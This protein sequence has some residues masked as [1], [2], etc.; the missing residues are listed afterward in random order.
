VTCRYAVYFAP[1]RE[2]RW[3]DFGARWLGR[4]DIRNEPLAQPGL[5]GLDAMAVQRITA[6]PRRYGF[7]ATLKAPF[8]LNASEPGDGLLA[9]L[10]LL[11]G[12]LRA[13]PLGLLVP[14]YM[15]GFVALVP[16]SP[17]PALQALAADCV[18]GLDDLRA[19]LTPAERDRRRIEPAD[20]RAADLFERFGY[21]HVLERFRFH[22]T[23]TGP[24]DMATAGRV[25]A[26]VAHPIAQ[27]NAHEPAVLDR[28][29]LFLEPE[30]GAAFR[31]VAEVELRA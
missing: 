1:P 12:H 28:L 19:P 7:H 26:Q 9:R 25:V 14:V 29:C 2:S 20:R 30:P 21:P 31:R 24:V 22:M 27:I 18:T 15:D 11:A 4:D 13:V 10:R 23:L 8:R 6:E 5:N 3:W 17:N 16:N